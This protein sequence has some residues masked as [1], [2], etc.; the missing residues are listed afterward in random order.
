MTGKNGSISTM[1][2]IKKVT[3]TEKITPPGVYGSAK[4]LIFEYDLNEGNPS[5]LDY[6]VALLQKFLGSRGTKIQMNAVEDVFGAGSS[7]SKAWKSIT[8]EDA[9]LKYKSFDGASLALLEGTFEDSYQTAE[10]LEDFLMSYSSLNDAIKK[11]AEK[12]KSNLEL[13]KGPQYDENL[14]PFLRQGMDVEEA[15]SAL[16]TIEFLNTPEG[17]E[18]LDAEAAELDRLATSM[19]NELI[20]GE[21]DGNEDELTDAELELLNL[22]EPE[23]VEEEA[24]IKDVE[25]LPIEEKPVGPVSKSEQYLKEL[26]DLASLPFQN[27]KDIVLGQ[28]WKML[29]TEKQTDLNYALALYKYVTASKFTFSEDQIKPTLDKIS[30]LIGNSFYFGTNILMNGQAYSVKNRVKGKVVLQNLQTKEFEEF[31]IKDFLN[32]VEQ[33]FAE[34]EVIPNLNVDTVVKV[35]EFAYIKGAYNDILNNFTSYMGE[36]NSLSEQELLSNLKKETTKCK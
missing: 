10:A 24:P 16:L 33:V 19:E 28:A 26:N 5:Q 12:I 18:I 17:Q 13:E 14:E 3:S 15:K 2:Q 31:E 32:S 35:E 20:N 1:Y 34:G 30:K 11:V 36:A 25:S 8:S 4:K 6:H 9:P 22:N 7:E 21:F 23:E 29:D 27:Q